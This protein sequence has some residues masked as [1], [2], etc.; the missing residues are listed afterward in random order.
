MSHASS[1]CPPVT[2]SSSHCSPQ[3]R[4]ALLH[5]AGTRAA[6][7]AG[8]VG[9]SQGSGWAHGEGC[10][11]LWVGKG[12]AG[13]RPAAQKARKAGS[14]AGVH[15]YVLSV[16]VRTA[17]PALPPSLPAN[18]SLWTLQFYWSYSFPLDTTR[19]ERERNSTGKKRR[20]SRKGVWVRTR[21]SGGGLSKGSKGGLLHSQLVELGQLL[22]GRRDIRAK[23]V[24]VIEYN[25]SHQ[26]SR[27]KL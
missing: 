18:L 11:L 19:S 22:R 15:N 3:C 20:I 7:L 13:T 8:A 6:S 10:C 24:I 27:T 25:K 2:A 26:K 5:P 17:S 21:E 16:P 4:P 12:G 9:M 14:R 23:K 1:G